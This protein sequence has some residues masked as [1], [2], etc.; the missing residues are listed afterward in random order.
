[1]RISGIGSKASTR[2]EANATLAAI[3]SAKEEAN[4]RGNKVFATEETKGGKASAREETDN[5]SNKAS[6]TIAK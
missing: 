2:E 5:D 6:A 4:D 3:A 1:V